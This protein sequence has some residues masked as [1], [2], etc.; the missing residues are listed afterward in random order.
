MRHSSLF[1]TGR[2]RLLIYPREYFSKKRVRFRAH[3]DAVIRRVRR[4]QRI[5]LAAVLASD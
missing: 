1:K 5:V 2:P 3:V 4:V